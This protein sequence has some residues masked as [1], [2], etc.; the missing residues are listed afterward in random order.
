[1]M[2]DRNP[3][4]NVSDTRVMRQ[5]IRKSC[6]LLLQV[7]LL[8]AAD[9]AWMSKPI[10]QW[11]E[12]DA[13]QVLT[14]SPWVKYARPALLPQLTEDQRRQGGQ[15]GGG[16]G[17]GLRGVGGDGV[18]APAQSAQPGKAKPGSSHEDVLTVRWESAFP[19]RVAVL[20][21]KEI[22]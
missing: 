10:Q 7:A 5:I 15:M 1:M 2:N 16:K 13:K 22:G 18:F 3:G 9:P 6:L 8:I 4:R 11:D 14:N 12:E 17:V 20:K 21:A 19:I